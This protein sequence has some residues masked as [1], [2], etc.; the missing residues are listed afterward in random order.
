M[1]GMRNLIRL[2]ASLG[3]LALA[4]VNPDIY[5]EGLR[6]RLDFIFRDEKLENT[7]MS[8]QVY[9][10]SKQ[11][12]L[13]ELGSNKALSP[14][15]VTKVITGLVALKKL[16]PNFTFKTEVL[17]DGPIKDGTLR[18]N[19]ILRGGGDPALVTERLYLLASEVR[20]NNIKVISGDILVDDSIFDQI[21]I[22]SNRIKTDTDRAYNAPVGG[23]SF[24]YNTTTLFFRSGDG[25]G[26]RAQA[27]V[28][29]DT[30]YIQLE[31]HGKTSERSSKYSL[32]ASRIKG[33]GGDKVQ[34]NGA[35]PLGFAEQHA[36][37]NITEPAIYAG[38]ALRFL[39]EQNGVKV[40]GKKVI[41]QETPSS[42]RK[43]AELESLPLR[44]IVVLMNKFSNNF[45]ADALVKMVGKQAYG[46]PGSMEKGLKV[47]N[48]ECTRLGINKNGFNYV[49]GSGLTR[50]NRMSAS[51]LVQLLNQS[52][53]DFDV[54]PE[55]L[56]S[57]PIAGQD[58]T[59]RSRFKGTS[60]YGKLRAKTGTIDGVSSLTG[61][62]QSKGGELLAFA[63]IMNDKS[64]SPGSMRPWQNYLGQALADFNRKNPLTEKPL[65][66]PDVIEAPEKA[67]D[68]QD[69]VGAR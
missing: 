39:L 67:A 25:V 48:E 11:E 63:V 9:S 29:P 60:A 22:D 26:A 8:I 17:V 43:I 51:S 21:K 27:Y 64:Q 66:I 69:E 40:S 36:Y 56:S 46:A 5:R 24:N 47:V 2:M 34:V 53:L 28:E 38:T 62:V 37:F 61:V 16:G 3:P 1:V 12:S 19:L 33:Q 13:Y 50:E 7:A 42:A 41:H 4:Q 31:N 55:L 57:F 54:L 59:L 32:A 14:A 6:K 15:S 58:G 45:I 49:S 44:E 30:G 68:A 35:I 65:A 18:G 23:L 52:Y 20:R 10:L